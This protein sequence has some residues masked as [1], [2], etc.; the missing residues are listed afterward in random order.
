MIVE[1][2]YAAGVN[3]DVR[4]HQCGHPESDPI[5][6]DDMPGEPTLYFGLTATAEA[7]V[8]PGNH[9]EDAP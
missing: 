7:E 4:C 5:D 9:R 3:G 2:D 8:V 6:V 1:H